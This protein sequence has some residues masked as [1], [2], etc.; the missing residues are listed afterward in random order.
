MRS[1]TKS[2]ELFIDPVV[3]VL[4]VGAQN[5]G[6]HS[7][8]KKFEEEV[9]GT[10]PPE[11]MM[12]SLQAKRKKTLSYD[13][14]KARSHSIKQSES[15]KS[16]E[17]PASYES[18]GSP[19]ERLNKIREK[20]MQTKPTSKTIK[21]KLNNEPITIIFKYLRGFTEVQDA[22]QLGSGILFFLDMSDRKSFSEA[23]SNVAEYEKHR[24]EQNFPVLFVANKCDTEVPQISKD[25]ICELSVVTNKPYYI[26]SAKQGKQVKETIEDLLAQIH[27]TKACTVW[28]STKGLIK[29]K[30]S[31]AVLNRNIHKVREAIA[32]GKS[33][34]TPSNI[35]WPA[36]H[37]ACWE[38]S[39]DYVRTLIQY[40]PACVNMRGRGQWT[41]LHCA[42]RAGNSVVVEFLLQTGAD[43]MVTDVYGLLASCTSNFRIRERLQHLEEMRKECEKQPP[44]ELDNLLELATQ[45]NSRRLHFSF[46]NLRDFS[47][48][49]F[50][51]VQLVELWLVSDSISC[52]P[53]ELKLLTN[54]R[55]LYLFG[56]IIEYVP[57]W[58]SELSHLTQLDLRCNRISAIN[59]S[60][61]QMKQLKALYLGYNRLTCLPAQI[62]DLMDTLEVLDI[63]G[64]PLG[65]IPSNI[66]PKLGDFAPSS[67]SQL[68]S[69]LKHISSGG[70]VE[71]NRVKVMFVGDGNVGKTTLLNSFQEHTRIQSRRHSFAKKFLPHQDTIA[72][73]GIDIREI[74]V[75]FQ[76]GKEI[77]WDCW[78]Y[79]GQEIYYSTHQFFLSPRSVYLICFNL[80]EN[81]HSKVE[82]WLNSIHSR[83]RGSPIFLVGT[84]LDDKQVTEEYLQEYMSKLCNTVKPERFISIPSV[85]GIYSVGSNK[86]IGIQVLIDG[87][88]QEIVKSKFV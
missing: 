25:N 57:E 44:A 56:N 73:D 64:N 28:N 87:L 81:N 13:S 85:K 77:L 19:V 40:D 60:I 1:R 18:D 66:L 5:C 11:A 14:T 30:L 75:P 84:H 65:T 45:H 23:R 63:Q 68:F 71:Y 12:E 46:M 42:A 35:G 31:H 48:S 36:I 50:Q 86:G 17:C 6:K 62:I 33:P 37:V 61:G 78:D 43:V 55:A 54:L 53:E 58:F 2:K 34:A 76:D 69:Y 29:S 20:L 26:A 88:S 27:N 8:V 3:T 21:Y 79:A 32:I 15:P 70:E 9:L 67:N 59:S 83:A 74:S 38:G 39:I 4:C 82:Y 49:I 51:Q 10:K 22:C 52:I 24:V 72:T 80:L 7:F 16:Q 47:T 41:P